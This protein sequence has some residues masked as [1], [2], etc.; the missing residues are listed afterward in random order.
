MKTR[1]DLEQEIMDCWQITNDI[2]TIFTHVMENDRL[3]RDKLANVL[4]G[5]KELYHLKFENCFNTFELLIRDQTI[6]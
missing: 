5:M 6:K 2:D 4:L 3:D 1:F